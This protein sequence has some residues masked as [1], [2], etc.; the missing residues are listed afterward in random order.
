MKKEFFVERQGQRFVLY[1][2]LLDEAHEQG[3]KS[4]T[5]SL[6]QI[7]TEENRH[8]AICQAVVEMQDGKT[9]SGIGDASPANV[10]R[11]MQTAIIRM[12]ETRAKA[13]AL[14]DAVNVG[15]AALEELD[16]GDH[17]DNAPDYR[18]NPQPGRARLLNNGN[19]GNGNGN[20]SS[21]P[22][23][24]AAVAPAPMP[25]VVQDEGLAT[26]KQ[27]QAIHN[28][29]YKRLFMSEEELQGRV[30]KSFGVPVEKLTRGDASQLI[31]SLNENVA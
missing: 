18:A 31:R 6:L 12:A 4:I 16:G 30:Q 8:I 15:A 14:R 3:L 9:F 24:P 10:S 25:A 29:A 28:L 1:A 17:Q 26:E 20:G 5:T 19:N 7:P 27:L 2:G 22:N 21:N 23:R 11:P 13:R